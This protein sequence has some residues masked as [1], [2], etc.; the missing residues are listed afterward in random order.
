MVFLKKYFRTASLSDHI[1]NSKPAFVV[2]EY[3]VEMA[4]I[5]FGYC[6]A[7][8]LAAVTAK[9]LE[10]PDEIAVVV[11]FIF[12]SG[13]V[14]YNLKYLNDKNKEYKSID[15]ILSNLKFLLD[16]D[17]NPAVVLDSKGKVVYSNNGF[18]KIILPSNTAYMPLIIANSLELNIGDSALFLGLFSANN[19]DFRNEESLVF[20]GRSL[21]KKVKLQVSLDSLS[22]LVFIRI[23]ISQEIIYSDLLEEFDLGYLELSKDHT[24]QHVNPKLERILGYRKGELSANES[25]FSLLLKDLSAR[26]D[27]KALLG[28]RHNTLV[29]KYGGEI[30]FLSCSIPVLNDL[31]ELNKIK[32]IFV[33][34]KNSVIG[35]NSKEAKSLW[36][37]YS[38]KCIFDN[39]P[40]PVCLLD[41]DGLV[42]KVNKAF[43][44]EISLQSEGKLFSELVMEKDKEK[45]SSVILNLIVGTHKNSPIVP[46]KL[47]NSTKFFEVYFGQV[48]NLDEECEGF[49]VRLSDVS[50]QKELEES[51]S[52]AQRMQTIGHLVGSVAHD[53]NNILTAISGFCDLLLL[54][55]S[56][57]DSSFASVMQ[58]K[59]SADRASNL[60]K[61]LLAFS[62]KQTLML[63]VVNPNELFSS[64]YQLIQRLIGS[65]VVFKQKI[66]PD[67]WN[68]I[69][70]PVQIEQV[71]L[72]L[73]VNAH[74]AMPKGGELILNVE[75]INLTN[76]SAQLR[77]L[78]I[79]E[80][81]E[82][83]PRGEY[84]KIVVEDSGT[85][86]DPEILP[87]IFEPFFTTKSDKS[88][89]GLG[90]S[91]V[92]GI[93]RQSEG[94][95]FVKTK[96]GVGTRFIILF[97]KAPSHIELSKPKSLNKEIQ[98]KETQNNSSY[99]IA[100]VEDEEAIR[101]FAKSVLTSKGYEVIDFPSAKIAYEAIGGS[102]VDIDLIVTDVMMPGMNG[103]TFVEKI[104]ENN[105]DIKVIFISGYAEEAFTEEYGAKRDFH[106][107]PKPFS[108]KDLSN[109]VL[110]VLNGAE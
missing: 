55:H 16:M 85:G 106:F 108:L 80:G 5:V 99:K 100:L 56:V 96:L 83:P 49:L 104:R 90:L 74:H 103:P 40:Y 81:E 44:K 61:R 78:F 69:I 54:K 7:F 86:I 2:K 13:A 97:K 63:E 32:S 59:Q 42:I 102:K 34:V 10:I 109:K 65:G 31:G 43:S 66:A 76:R 25:N 58:I 41:K 17:E 18:D 62:R 79:P 67:C 35:H 12:A 57:G 4:L 39:S 33:P 73:V 84:V 105:P 110:E 82:M 14:I 38:W 8:L 70:D 20:E 94:Y 36:L 60:V 89:T 37:E 91:T 98:P 21:G 45:I 95:I 24:I 93:I 53:F 27:N 50:K 46:I 15:Q 47:M 29:G 72:N 6:L 11:F 68:M 77:D 22:S 1:R 75:N 88:G 48:L 101:I 30:E 23:I 92:Y 107:I 19:L 26:N 87:K 51:F 3:G 28:V 52:H 9:I 64:F 71:I